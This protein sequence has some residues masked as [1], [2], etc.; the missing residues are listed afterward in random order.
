LLTTVL[1]SIVAATIGMV[2]IQISLVAGTS[3]LSR[4]EVNQSRLAV[5]VGLSKMSATLEHNPLSIYYQVLAEESSRLCYLEADNPV[6][7]EAGSVWPSD[8]GPVW[9]YSASDYSSGVL[10]RPPS[11]DSTLVEVSAFGRA[12]EVILGRRETYSILGQASPSLYSGTSLD[13]SSTGFDTT[14]YKGIIYSYEEITLTDESKFAQG[15]I[16]ASEKNS[17]PGSPQVCQLK[18]THALGTAESNGVLDIRNVYKVPMSPGGVDS[19]LS[20]LGKVACLDESPILLA[21]E[22]TALCLR[23]GKTLVDAYGASRGMPAVAAILVTATGDPNHINIYSSDSS[24]P[25]DVFVENWTLLGTYLYP[26]SGVL[27]SDYALYVGG[28]PAGSPN[29]TNT[30]SKGLTVVAGSPLNRRDI[31]V[32]TSLQGGG[33]GL[34]ASGTVRIVAPSGPVA[35]SIDAA[36]LA[37]GSP[38]PPLLSSTPS[39]PA[40]GSSLRISGQMVLS[41]YDVSLGGF[42]TKTY[43]SSVSSAPMFPAPLL[44]YLRT[45]AVPL[46]ASQAADLVEGTTP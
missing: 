15:S 36:I 5:D 31:V 12:G 23:P 38:T 24:S 46:T 27:Y 2:A 19:A 3:E 29:C 11:P 14:Q 4:L 22:V 25:A 32:G 18:C 28:C 40:A 17:S 30:F 34:V 42:A 44:K 7:V 9:G 13:V 26:S 41:R 37:S 21:G 1:V 10:V 43:T 8:C 45:S 20:T 35:V 39:S 6:T 33:L 16:V